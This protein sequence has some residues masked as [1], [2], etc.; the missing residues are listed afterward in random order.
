MTFEEFQ[1]HMPILS[2]S[3]FIWQTAHGSQ[4]RVVKKSFTN[5]PCKKSQY[6]K[7][8]LFVDNV[9]YVV[10]KYIHKHVLNKCLTALLQ[11]KKNNKK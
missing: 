4:H 11:K 6:D 1:N 7:L 10:K 3:L 9:L 5:D 2:N 8:K